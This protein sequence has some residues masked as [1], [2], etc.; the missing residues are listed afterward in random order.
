MKTTAIVT[1][2]LIGT[3]YNTQ[4]ADNRARRYDAPAARGITRYDAPATHIAGRVD[5][6]TARNTTYR[7]PSAHRGAKYNAP[8][9][10]NTAEFRA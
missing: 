3:T 9:A 6:P 1:A 7:A 2:A 5:A 8:G 4:A 10:R